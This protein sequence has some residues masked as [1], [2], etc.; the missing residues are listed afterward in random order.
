M[1]RKETIK[2]RMEMVQQKSFEVDVINKFRGKSLEDARG[3]KADKD[4]DFVPG[5]LIHP[6]NVIKMH[7]D[8]LVTALLL[9]SC[10]ATPV[11]IALWEDL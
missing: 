3:F 6:G 11:Q 10:I 7:W 2:K 4:E 9:F 8:I 1:K 5:G